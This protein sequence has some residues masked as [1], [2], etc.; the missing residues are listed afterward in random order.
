MTKSRRLAGLFALLLALGAL[1]GQAPPPVSADGDMC[2]GDPVVRFNGN[3]DVSFTV[4]VPVSA[5][6]AITKQN[7][8]ILRIYVPSNVTAQVVLFT[9]A[10]AERVDIV[11]TSTVASGTSFEVP[12]ETWAPTPV[13]GAAYRYNYSAVSTIA[14]TQYNANSGVWSGWAGKAIRVPLS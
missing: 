6:P 11:R 14:S 4:R 8:V 12:Y 13:G 2:A 10:L 9:G 3:A 7:P 5:V 1:V